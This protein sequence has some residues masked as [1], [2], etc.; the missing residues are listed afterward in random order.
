MSRVE[1]LVLRA[2][3][4]QRLREWMRS[5]TI[6]TGLAQRARIVLLAAQGSSSTEVGRLAVDV[7]GHLDLQRQLH[8]LELEQHRRALTLLDRRH[9]ASSQGLNRLRQPDT[10][11][12]RHHASPGAFCSHGHTPGNH[13]SQAAR[14][15][16]P[17][18]QEPKV[19]RRR[20]EQ[21]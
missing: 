16:A 20:R 15:A 5:A 10:D 13:A 4:E 18:P 1:P 14:R 21:D 19:H 17:R 3:D 12:H 2:G 7:L 9:Q 6:P 11:N 8:R